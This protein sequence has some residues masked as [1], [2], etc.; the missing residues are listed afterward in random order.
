MYFTI[1]LINASTGNRRIN[2][3]DSLSDAISWKNALERHT[4][5][6]VSILYKQGAEMSQV[7]A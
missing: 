6:D 3:F 1:E 2:V 4:P 5:S 7:V